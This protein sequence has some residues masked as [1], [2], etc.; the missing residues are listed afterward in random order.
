[1]KLLSFI[2]FATFAFS[3]PIFADGA[4]PAWRGQYLQRYPLP[5]IYTKLVND[6]GDGY[7]ALYG[8]RNFREVLPGLVYRGGANNA[9]NKHGKRSNSN[10]LP[11]E[12]LN[13]LCQE[14]FANSVYLYSTNYASSAHVAN[15]APV[16]PASGHLDYSQKSPLLYKAAVQDMLKLVYETIN[17]RTNGPVYL[18]CWNGWHA[19]GYISALILRQFCGFTPAQAVNYWNIN[20]DGNNKGAEYDKIRANIS[21]YVADPALTISPSMQSQICPRP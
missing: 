13:H 10:P 16:R 4:P 9:F 15:C 21:A 14:G 8:V 18:H 6:H 1:M 7:E 5:D 12:G 19:S 3:T 11:L 2:V 20:T 17:G